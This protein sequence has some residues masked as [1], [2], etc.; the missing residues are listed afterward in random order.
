MHEQNC[1]RV[2]R[3]KKIT[4]RA[5]FITRYQNTRQW[6]FN[7]INIAVQTSRQL[8]AVARPFGPCSRGDEQAQSVQRPVGLRSYT[9]TTDVVAKEVTAANFN[10]SGASFRLISWRYQPHPISQV[11]TLGWNVPAPSFCFSLRCFGLRRMGGR[12]TEAPLI[13]DTS[14]SVPLTSDA[15]VEA[16]LSVSCLHGMNSIRW[17]YVSRG[18]NTGDSDARRDESLFFRFVLLTNGIN[19]SCP[20]PPSTCH[21]VYTGQRE[22]CLA[23]EAYPEMDTQYS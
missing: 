18:P 13:P 8:A 6:K 14:I 17:W 9:A 7:Y 20:A 15:R 11:T 19:Y 21:R 3:Q 23:P 10:L 12:R 2:A 16:F 22:L 4:Q 1:P 5:L